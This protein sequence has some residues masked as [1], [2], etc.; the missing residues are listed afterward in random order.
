[1]WTLIGL[2]TLVTA[3][4]AYLPVF[5]SL[6][7]EILD[8]SISAASVGLISSVGSVAGFAS[9]YMFGYLREKTGTFTLGLAILGTVAL[10]MARAIFLVPR[11]KAR[12][13]LN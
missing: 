12:V 8:P 3:G 11:V 2:L 7:T 9:P 13:S 6:P 1:V 4:N 10:A 5:W